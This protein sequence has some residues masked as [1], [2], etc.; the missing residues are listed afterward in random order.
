M[1]LTDKENTDIDKCFSVMETFKKGVETCKK[2][3]TDCSCWAN[4]VK[5]V[6]NVTDCRS[7][8]KYIKRTGE[9]FE[10]TFIIVQCMIK[11]RT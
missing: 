1:S 8:G 5:T 7:V 9:I 2:N 10:I 6:G 3:E 11:K 4:L